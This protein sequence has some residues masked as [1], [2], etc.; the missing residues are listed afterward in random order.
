MDNQE[1]PRKKARRSSLTSS[2]GDLLSS[3]KYSDLEIRCDG[4][5]F[6]VHRNIVCGRSNVMDTECDGGFL[7]AQTR[8]IKHSVF[9][10]SA[11]DRMLQFMYR[12]EY[13][14]EL[15][16]PTT[17]DPDSAAQNTTDAASSALEPNAQEDEANTEE[18]NVVTS[19]EEGS[20]EELLAHVY[21]FA[22]ADYYEM[23]VLQELAVMKFRQVRKRIEAIAAEDLIELASVVYTNTTDDATDLRGQLFSLVWEN[24]WVSYSIQSLNTSA[25]A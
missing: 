5:I 3:G 1:G 21:V 8:I 7:E 13:E 14:L 25:K 16:C 18:G 9:D 19:V 11:M 15:A 22:I 24:P 2:I 23:P 4:K 10:S 17:P 6:K 20:E 12:S